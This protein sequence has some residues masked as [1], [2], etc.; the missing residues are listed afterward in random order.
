MF[1]Q[2]FASISGIEHFSMLRKEAI[3]FMLSKVAKNIFHAQEK[4]KGV[5]CAT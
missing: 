5:H 3:F 2:Q 4:G 1:S